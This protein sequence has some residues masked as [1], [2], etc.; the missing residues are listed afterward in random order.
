MSSQSYPY[1]LAHAVVARVQFCFST[2]TSPMIAT[3]Y[4]QVCG[5]LPRNSAPVQAQHLDK[6][7][8]SHLAWRG[9]ACL[10]INSVASKSTIGHQRGA[11]HETAHGRREKGDCVSDLRNVS[12]CVL[13]GKVCAPTSSIMAIRLSGV[14][15]MSNASGE[16]GSML[17]FALIKGVST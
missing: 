10:V 11:G 7:L 12:I 15:S 14:R 6:I 9:A 8:T 4:F 16:P 5:L 13:N 3:D 1:L 2:A 17:I